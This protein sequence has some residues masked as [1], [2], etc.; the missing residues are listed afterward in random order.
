MPR[1]PD[2]RRASIRA[3]LAQGR[4]QVEVARREGLAE[5]TVSRIVRDV[6][7]SVQPEVLERD[8]VERLHEGLTVRQMAAELEVDEDLVRRSL[9][10]YRLPLVSSDW[11]R[12]R[13]LEG[14]LT[15]AEMAAE[16]DCHPSMMLRYMVRAGIP[17]RRTGY[18]STIDA[19][20]VRNAITAGET[21]VG[22]GQRMG[23]SSASV[24]R[25]VRG[26][27]P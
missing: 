25:I 24:S 4:S 10:R 6:E 9:R 16:A 2:A 23:I 11:L 15:I 5:S 7:R 3:A 22:V 18:R 21:Q 8:V 17:R 14:G 20:A 13:Y 1:I 19:A 26:S 27:M 12:Q